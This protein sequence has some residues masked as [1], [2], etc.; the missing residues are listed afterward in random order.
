MLESLCHSANAFVTLTYAEDTI[1]ENASLQPAHM[2]EF[3]KRLREHCLRKEQKKIRFYGVGEYGDTTER[4]HYHLLLFGYQSCLRGQSMYSRVAT[5]CCSRC[6]LIKDIWGYGHVALGT[7]THQSVRYV[8][9]YMTKNMRHRHD[10]RLKGREPE[11]A[12]M[13]L[14][15]GIGFAALDEL[16]R[17][18]MQ[19]DLDETEKVP[20]HLRHGEIKRPL[21]RYLR[22]K[23]ADMLDMDKECV[24]EEMQAVWSAAVAATPSGGEVRRILFK[25]MLIE[26]AEQRI[27]NIKSR[28]AIKGKR[29]VL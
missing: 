11:F 28:M 17:T 2:Q 8:C 4:P 3:L 10:P 20:T 12:R 24:D 18:I 23:L 19:Y 22:G 6:D 26:A 1:T 5:S 27:L 15:P 29:E 9:G 25:N 21:G 7:V 16:T 13:S 14:R